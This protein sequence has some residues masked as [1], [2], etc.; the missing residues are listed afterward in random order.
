MARIDE[1]LK[2]IDESVRLGIRAL[3]EALS[4]SDAL[5][6]FRKYGVEAKDMDE[7]ELK[8]AFRGLAMANHPDR[9]GDEEA[10]KMITA[11]Y[12]ALQKGGQAAPGATYRDRSPR[13]GGGDFNKD[14]DFPIWA[15]A[16]HSG[17]MRNQGHIRREDYSDLNYFK[18][19][20]YELSGRSRQAWT[21]WTFDGNFFR[22]SVTVYGSPEIFSEMAKAVLQWEDTFYRKNAVFVQR[23]GEDDIQLIWLDG[24]NI[25]PPV[26]FEHDSFNRNPG[27][28]HRFCDKLPEM[29]ADVK[30]RKLRLS[31]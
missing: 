23:Y 22:S 7:A 25:S 5:N 18:R 11:A 19:Q 28:D 6:I 24:E 15:N 4:Y 9:G 14:G 8:K 26:R 29:L 2:R 31:A 12:D 20:M 13:N 21:I 27:N 17:G 30:N 3:Y 1:A 16:G 10:L